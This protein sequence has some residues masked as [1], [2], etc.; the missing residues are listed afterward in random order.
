MIECDLH[1]PYQQRLLTKLVHFENWNDGPHLQADGRIFIYL[2]IYF[3]I[4]L[5]SHR[6]HF[7]EVR[8]EER[9]LPDSQ[10]HSHQENWNC[11]HRRNQKNIVGIILKECTF[12]VL[13]VIWNSPWEK[14]RYMADLQIF[15][16]QTPSPVEE[17]TSPVEWRGD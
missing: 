3:P 5:Y 12:F 11:V 8:K 2:F 15:I 13:L 7:L 4:Y 14:L 6:C 9:T 10:P 1:M 16:E 17:T